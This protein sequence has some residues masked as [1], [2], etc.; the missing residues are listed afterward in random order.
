[1][2][3]RRECRGPAFPKLARWRRYV[4]V[5]SVTGVYQEGTEHKARSGARRLIPNLPDAR[6]MLVELRDAGDPYKGISYRQKRLAMARNSGARFEGEAVIA[7][8]PS[9]GLRS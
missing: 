7:V 5:V 2:R 8:E 1:V 4:Q 6:T 9:W 3:E